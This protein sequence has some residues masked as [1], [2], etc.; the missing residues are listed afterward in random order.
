M[1]ETKRGVSTKY[2]MF[3]KQWHEDCTIAQATA[4]VSFNEVQCFVQ[5]AV[6]FK[7]FDQA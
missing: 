7:R 2:M 4:A 1:V 3:Y 6:V 5:I